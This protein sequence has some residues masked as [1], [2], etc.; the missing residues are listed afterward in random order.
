M[1]LGCYE[2]EWRSCFTSE[3][4]ENLLNYCFFDFTCWFVGINGYLSWSFLLIDYC[5]W[6]YLICYWLGCWMLVIELRDYFLLML[7]F[8]VFLFV[9]QSSSLEKFGSV[10]VKPLLPELS[11]VRVWVTRIEFVSGIDLHNMDW[12]KFR[13]SWSRPDPFVRFISYM[14]CMPQHLAKVPYLHSSYSRAPFTDAKWIAQHLLVPCP[15]SSTS[16]TMP[17]LVSWPYKQYIKRLNLVIFVTL[18]AWK[19]KNLRKWSREG[20]G[21]KFLVINWLCTLDYV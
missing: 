14:T 21:Y 18:M 11:W 20:G 10:G 19:S 2:E 17:L 5:W 1:T 6:W 4:S 3:D 16:F 15:L 13:L 12:V 7:F 9:K 8:V